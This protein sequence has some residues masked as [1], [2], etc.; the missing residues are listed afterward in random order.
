MPVSLFPTATVPKEW[1]SSDELQ[2]RCMWT[3]VRLLLAHP[4]HF[5]CSKV[6]SESLKDRITILLPQTSSAREMHST[7]K[8]TPNPGPSMTTPSW[9]GLQD[10]SFFT[11]PCPRVPTRNLHS[12]KYEDTTRLGKEEVWGVPCSCSIWRLILWVL[13]RSQEFTDVL[14]TLLVFSIKKMVNGLEN[15]TSQI[16]F[17][18]HGTF[19]VHINLWSIQ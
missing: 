18:S 2:R 14:C 19:W 11:L 3:N 6:V 17:N 5:D 12:L 4:P 10:I 15:T 9:S 8:C 1:K 13:Q 7:S 16:P